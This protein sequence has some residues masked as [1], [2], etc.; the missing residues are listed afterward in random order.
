MLVYFATNSNHTAHRQNARYGTPSSVATLHAVSIL[1]RRFHTGLPARNRLLGDARPI[2]AH[3]AVNHMAATAA[4]TA[5]AGIG[6]LYMLCAS[7]FDG[8]EGEWT[9]NRDII[10]GRATRATTSDW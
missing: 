7:R 2:Q 4:R 6:T 3:A 10:G 9:E 8:R 1:A 5:A